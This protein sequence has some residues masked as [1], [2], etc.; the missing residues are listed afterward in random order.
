MGRLFEKIQSLVNQE[1]YVIAQHAA[2]RLEERGILEWQVVDGVETGSLII[3]RTKTLPN[4]AVEILEILADGTQVK[5]VWS[6][7]IS[8]DVAKLVTVH[9]FDE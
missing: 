9:F 6:H 2:E 1:R 4:P 3:E 5:A 7:I 8:A